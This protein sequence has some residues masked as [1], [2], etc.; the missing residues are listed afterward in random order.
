MKGVWH[1]CKEE[2]HLTV[3][4]NVGFCNRLFSHLQKLRVIG[5]IHCPSFIKKIYQQINHGVYRACIFSRHCWC[6]AVRILMHFPMLICFLKK[7]INYWKMYWLIAYVKKILQKSNPFS[8]LSISHKTAVTST[9]LAD[10]HCFSLDQCFFHYFMLS[11][12]DS[13]I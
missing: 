1:C 9:F 2:W 13:G 11:C 7:P 10:K 12:F 6:S 8:I 3:V 4:T 5:S